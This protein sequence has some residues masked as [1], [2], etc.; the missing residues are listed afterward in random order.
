MTTVKFRTG[1]R[2]TRT[3]LAI[4]LSKKFKS[5]ERCFW[6]KFFC[7][8]IVKVKWP[9]TEVLSDPNDHYRSWVEEHIGR[10][11]IHWDW[12]LQ[13]DD[14]RLNLL[15]VGLCKSKSPYATII[16]LMWS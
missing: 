3:P 16:A 12:R 15:T 11:C 13:D 1:Y 6:W 8:T 4:T 5:L 14:I 9:T 10:Q 2:G 7:H